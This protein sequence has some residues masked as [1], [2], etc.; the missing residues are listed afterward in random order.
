VAGTLMPGLLT[1]LDNAGLIVNGAKVFTYITGTTTKPSTYS[2]AALS[3]ANANPT[4][5]DSAGRGKMYLD[6]SASNYDIYVCPSDAADPPLSSYYTLTN[7]SAVPADDEA[8][9]DITVTAGENITAGDWVY[10]SLGDG[11]RTVGRWYK[12]DSDLTYASTTA[13]GLGVATA[14]ISSAASGNIRIQ[15]TYSAAT[16]LV[17][18]SQYYLSG[19][20]GAISSTPPA[21]DRAVAIA[22]STTSYLI[23]PQ[24][25]FGFT[26]GTG[27]LVRATS[28]TLTTPALGTPASGVLTNCTGL[29]SSALIGTTGTGDVAKAIGPVLQIPVLGVPASGTLTNCTGLPLTTGITGT[30][31][32]ANGGTG[33]ERSSS[34][35][36]NQLLSGLNLRPTGRHSCKCFVSCYFL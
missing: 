9:G 8:S 36:R 17:A 24:Q 28:A 2:S 18:G 20:A 21:D 1:V 23:S 12:T 26:T 11:G 7:V 6:P 30:L 16:G 35:P 4:V 32:V 34:G 25:R 27:A 13:M 19:T 3:V 22:S 5:A 31:A 15:G 10:L 29:P 14:D 33:R